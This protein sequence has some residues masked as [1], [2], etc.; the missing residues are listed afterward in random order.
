MRK[1]GF[2]IN[3]MYRPAYF[4]LCIGL[5]VFSFML[6]ILAISLH[7][8][9]L[10]GESDIIYRYPKMIKEILFPIYILLPTIFAVDIRERN[11][12]KS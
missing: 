12:N 2:Y 8:D 7:A 4:M 10:A 3:T 1:F 11:K 6:C 9:I 5:S